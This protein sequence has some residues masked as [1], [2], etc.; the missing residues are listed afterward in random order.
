M[1][2]SELII[3]LAQVQRDRGDV[4]VMMEFLSIPDEEVVV[5]QS[6]VGTHFE[7]VQ[8]VQETQIGHSYYAQLFI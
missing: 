2:I 8:G 6:D 1:K 5:R 7:E 3:E 4:N